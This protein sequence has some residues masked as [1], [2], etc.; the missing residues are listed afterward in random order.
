[1]TYVIHHFPSHLISDLSSAYHT[2]FIDG[3]IGARASPSCRSAPSTRVSRIA[4]QNTRR[5][6]SHQCI[7]EAKGPEYPVYP[8]EPAS[9][10][11]YQTSPLAPAPPAHSCSASHRHPPPPAL[12][13]VVPADAGSSRP[14]AP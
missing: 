9:R 5:A 8:C 14:S 6:P 13:E 1:M 4:D 3:L 7:P 10:L 11:E 2:P 12:A